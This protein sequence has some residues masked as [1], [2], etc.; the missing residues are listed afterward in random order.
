MQVAEIGE[1][2]M[3]FDTPCLAQAADDGAAD[4]AVHLPVALRVAPAEVGVQ[5][6]ARQIMGEESLR[7][8]LDKGEPAHP[9][10]NVVRLRRLQHGGEGLFTGDPRVGAGLQ[11]QAVSRT[12]DLLQEALEQRA[13]QIRRQLRTERDGSAVLRQYVGNERQGQ[14][15][16]M[17]EGQGG[18]MLVG[19]NSSRAEVGAAFV[20]P[21]VAERENPYQILPT[22]VRAP[23]RGGWVSSRDDDNVALGELGQK[24]L[25]QPA[26]QRRERLVGV[27]DQHA[28]RL[29]GQRL[30]RGGVFVQS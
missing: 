3:L 12:G 4:P 8:L 30:Q 6:L 25:A 29:P 15:V 2:A 22:G 27:D 13:H 19:G 26:V 24:R 28:A 7:P 1:R 5:H 9:G 11:R 10:E 14:R 23:G 18:R 21:Q 20:R 16:A 17:C